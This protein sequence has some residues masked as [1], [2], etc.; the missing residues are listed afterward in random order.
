LNYY[1]DIICRKYQ[2]GFD[3]LKRKGEAMAIGRIKKKE[4]SPNEH[5]KRSIL[6]E[7]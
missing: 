3:D 5:K 7:I 2:S 4:V 6:T 1:Q